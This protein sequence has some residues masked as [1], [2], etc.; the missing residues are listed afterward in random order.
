MRLIK[1]SRFQTILILC[2]SFWLTSAGHMAWL[3][4][5]MALTTAEASQQ[6]ATV[7]GYAAQAVGIGMFALLNKRFSVRLQFR[8]AVPLYTALLAPSVPGGLPAA[9]ACGLAMSLLCGV[10][11]GSYL[12]RLAFCT[13]KKHRAQTFGIGYGA[14]TVAGGA[15]SLPQTGTLVLCGVLGAVAVCLSFLPA[16]VFRSTT[17]RCCKNISP[18]LKRTYRLALSWLF[19]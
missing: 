14:A 6:L 11:A 4:H 17:Q 2:I 18:I 7:G 5:L 8:A 12:H 3:Y 1:S 13:D 16:T 9:A 15:L 19:P 10:I